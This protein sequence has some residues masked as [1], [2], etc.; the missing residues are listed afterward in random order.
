M[1]TENHIATERKRFGKR[2]FGLSF[3]WS[4]DGATQHLPTLVYLRDWVV[5]TFQSALQGNFAASTWDMSIG[6]GS[7]MLTSLGFYAFG[8]VLNLLAVAVPRE[9]IGVAF[10]GIAILRLYLSGITF[11]AFARRFQMRGYAVLMAA[12][13]Y[14]L[15]G[16]SLFMVLRHP[17]FIDPL[18]Y[19]PLVCLGAEK[20]LHGESPVLFIV[21]F[22]LMFCAHFYFSYMVCIFAVAYVVCRLCMTGGRSAK[23]VLI[24]AL[25]YIGCGMVA[26]CLAS[27]LLLP[28]ALAVMGDWPKALDH[29]LGA[30]GKIAPVRRHHEN[31]AVLLQMNG[32]GIVLQSLVEDKIAEDDGVI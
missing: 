11:S 21:S 10:T 16:F 15:S 29:L 20:I 19:L 14:A 17:H 23:D 7:D 26:A 30:K 9:H 31:P 18:I 13:L 5:A 3:V 28:N 27:P 2:I 4:T 1:L 22:W 32:E 8:D 24:L 6:L 25:K 12:L